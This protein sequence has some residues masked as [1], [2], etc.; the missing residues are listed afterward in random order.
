MDEKL[1]KYFDGMKQ[2]LTRLIETDNCD[3]YWLVEDLTQNVLREI[4]T[5]GFLA[6]QEKIAIEVSG[7]LA[8]LLTGLKMGE[9]FSSKISNKIFSDILAAIKSVKVEGK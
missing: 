1:E 9:P 2:R 8:I 3:A 7:A 5:A 4:H 6:A